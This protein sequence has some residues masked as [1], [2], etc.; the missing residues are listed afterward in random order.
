MRNFVRFSF[1][2]TLF[3]YLVIFTGGLV[4]V[5]GAGLG[6]PDWPRCFGRWLPPLSYNQLPEGFDP[7]QVNLM[8]AWIEYLNRI[9]GVILG[10]LIAITAILAIKNFRKVP[11]VLVPSVLAGLLVAFLGWQGGQVVEQHLEPLLVSM[12]MVTALV[13][14]SL[15]IYATLRAYYFLNPDMASGNGRGRNTALWIGALWILA[16]VQVL[17]GTEMRAGLEIAAEQFPLASDLDLMATLGSIKYIHP[18]L[19]GIVALLTFFVG[20]RLLSLVRSGGLARQGIWLA[21]LLVVVQLA[22]GLGL[23]SIGTPPF[24]QVF[25]LWIGALLVGT[26][27]MTYTVLRRPEEVAHG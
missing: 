6:C 9:L 27:L 8:L 15:L 23:V 3:T 16:V 24:L 25:H 5:S 17:L 18:V 12:H 4:R 21:M 20:L 14:A 7:A 19:G 10:I 11:G 22:L 2:S 26:L 1:I 13:V